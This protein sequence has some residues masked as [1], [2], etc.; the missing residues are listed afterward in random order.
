MHFF[1]IFD[2]QMNLLR[3]SEPFKFQNYKV[4]FCLG[5]IVQDKQII[6]SYSV[7]DTQSFISVYSMKNVK[8]INWY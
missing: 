6:L 4:E 1:A 7:M 8:D 3:Y 5:L 2:L